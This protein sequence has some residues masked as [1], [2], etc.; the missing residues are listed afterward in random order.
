M[1]HQ[2]VQARFDF[3]EHLSVAIYDRETD[4]LKTLLDSG[5]EN[6]IMVRYEARFS[7]VSGLQALAA[8]GEPRVIDDLEALVRIRGPR[9]H[10]N[11]LLASGMRS[12]YTL[13]LLHER[14]F[15]GFVFF[16]STQIGRFG[17]AVTVHLDPF[18]RLMGLLVV[19]ELH[20]IRRLA[21]ATRTVRH[22]TSRRDC[23]TGAHLERMSRYARLIARGLASCARIQ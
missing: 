10:T 5:V 16:N 15:R 8:R 12:S 2:V 4:T 6:P 13:P 3:I 11:R 18:A 23:E 1:L 7:E 22:I 17:P 20:Q 14:K 19:H 9:E 21:A